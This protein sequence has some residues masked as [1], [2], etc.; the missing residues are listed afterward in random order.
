[1]EEQVT[2]DQSDAEFEMTKH[3]VAV[4]SSQETS[5]KN[6]QYKRNIYQQN[7]FRITWVHLEKTKTKYY[8]SKTDLLETSRGN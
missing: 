4:S 2:S 8:R 5:N 6:F 3:V 7:Y 1:M